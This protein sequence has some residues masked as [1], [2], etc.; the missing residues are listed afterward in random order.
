MHA[1]IERIKNCSVSTLQEIESAISALSLED[2]AKLV[3]DLP[4][5]LPEWEGDLAWQKIIHDSTPSSSLSKLADDIDAEFRRNPA[6]FPE[7]TE[8]DFNRTS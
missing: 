1:F 3:R 8:S 7:I 4:A 5:L 6:A 2:R